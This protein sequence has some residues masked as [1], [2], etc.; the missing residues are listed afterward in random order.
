MHIKTKDVRSLEHIPWCNIEP[1]GHLS[2]IDLSAVLTVER[3][4]VVNLNGG[5]KVAREFS[6]DGFPVWGLSDSL[7]HR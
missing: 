3:S 1:F 5:I 4:V 6:F 7:T 2:R